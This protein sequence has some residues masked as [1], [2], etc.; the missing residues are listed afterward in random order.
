MEG[1]TRQPEIQSTPKS[2]EKKTVMDWRPEGIRVFAIFV[3]VFGHMLFYSDYLINDVRNPFVWLGGIAIAAFFACSGYVHGLKDEFNKPGSLTPSK[4]VRFFKGRAFRLYI[5]Y[6]IALVVVLGAKL[7]AGYGIVFSTTEPLT[8]LVTDPIRIT[9]GSLILDLTC[10][11]PFATF[12]LGGIFPEAWFICS[13][14]ILS[15][16]YP[17][18]RRLYSIRK[19]SLYLIIIIATIF[20]VYMI[21]FVNA[22]YAYYFPFAWTAEFSVGIIVGDHICRKGGPNPPDKAYKRFMIS[23]AARIWPIY[24]FHI[25]VVVFISHHAPFWEFLLITLG[26]IVLAE[27]FHRLL[28]LI[29]KRGKKKRTK[30]EKPL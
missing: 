12:A 29:Y 28:S 15:L 1:S 10:M 14:L 20:R 16:T 24:L 5:G 7:M 11:W 17:V 23:A 8:F 4:Y 6:Y 27:G 25:A 13:M 21:I 19:Y 22:D 26:V 3:V 2:H 30:G 18:L 9:P